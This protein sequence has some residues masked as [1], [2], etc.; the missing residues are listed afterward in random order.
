MGINCGM[1]Y[2]GSLKQL[3]PSLARRE[4]EEGEL[5]TQLDTLHLGRAQRQGKLKI[6]MHAVYWTGQPTCVALVLSQPDLNSDSCV[7]L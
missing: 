6:D 5:W 2:N 7:G 4:K 3:V 1:Y